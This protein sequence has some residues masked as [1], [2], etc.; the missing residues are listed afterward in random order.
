M[1]FLFYHFILPLSRV[2]GGIY[3]PN[4]QYLLLTILVNNDILKCMDPSIIAY[5]LEEVVRIQEGS[6]W[7]EVTIVVERRKIVSVKV[8]NQSKVQVDEGR[9][10]VRKQKPE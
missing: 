4:I 3:H 2:F 10:V 1:I 9:T 7:G 5:V 6:G 8:T